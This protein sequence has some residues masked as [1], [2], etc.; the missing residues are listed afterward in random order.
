LK[1]ELETKYTN[2]RLK[3]LIDNGGFEKNMNNIN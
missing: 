3:E 1:S 2:N